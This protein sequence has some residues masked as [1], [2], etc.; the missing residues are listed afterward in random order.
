MPA[1]APNRVRLAPLPHDARAEDDSTAAAAEPE[2]A[3]AAAPT[4]LRASEYPYASTFA[5]SRRRTGWR[6][7]LPAGIDSPADL[8][9]NARAWFAAVSRF[10]TVKVAQVLCVT[11]IVV[12]T[13][14]SSP[15]GLVDPASGFIIDPTNAT[16][17]AA[18]LLGDRPVVASNHLQMACLAVSRM[19]AFSL[20]PVMI[21][22]F[23]SKCKATINFLEGTRL[24]LYMW[25]D[26]HAL[27]IYCGHYI[28]FDVWV[29]TLF[30]LI[31]W[32][33]AGNISLLWT[34]PT[35]VSG[36]VVVLATPLITLP[37]LY[38]KTTL[39]Y[40]VRKAL[41]YLFYVFA[42]GMCFH[43]PA[44]GVPNGGFLPYVLGACIVIYFLDA[45]YIEMFM[46][47]K[48]ETTT[49]HVLPSGVQMTMAVSSRFQ[50]RF[51]K[52]GYAYVCLPWVSRNQWHA[53]SL[54]KDPVD[55]NRRQVFMQKSG[56]W[57]S[58]VHSALQ[59]NTVRPIIV[60]GPFCSPYQSAMLYDNQVCSPQQFNMYNTA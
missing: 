47:E 8:V 10:W 28:A 33:T 16:A 60:Q 17:T 27:H 49:F 11:Y 52:G 22:V 35:G 39:P 32:G 44:S 41:H 31:R 51:E 20:Y 18:G 53:F 54:F 55:S 30:H 42:V 9:N 58:A 15:L 2:P 1:L 38:M 45:M 34:H 48:I 23:L 50:S 7:I 56:D 46:T 24:T 57:S 3:A 21:L 59:R 6:R 36:L 14:S 5:V 43:V 13:F 19:S 29:H 4:K 40:E 37:M 12:L 25:H 26:M